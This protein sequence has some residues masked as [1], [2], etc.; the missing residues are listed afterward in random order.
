MRS[1]VLS[2]ILLII[3]LSSCTTNALLRFSSYGSHI[4]VF[5]LLHCNLPLSPYV[6]VTCLVECEKSTI[7]VTGL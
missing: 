3:V 1:S 7:Y 2:T 4:C 6:V 5:C